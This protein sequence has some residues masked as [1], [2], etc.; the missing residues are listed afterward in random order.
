VSGLGGCEGGRERGDTL[1]W[2]LLLPHDQK[3]VTQTAQPH[4]H[5]RARNQKEQERRNGMSTNSAEIRLRAAKLLAELS[6][7][8][9]ADDISALTGD[10]EL[11]MR[12]AGL[13]GINTLLQGY[14]RRGLMKRCRY[15]QNERGRCS[16]I[17]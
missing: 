3:L 12:I 7:P 5:H 2:V 17:K 14:E 8:L 6:E 15:Q 4:L 11:A 16:D 1:W 9:S 10:D 13:N